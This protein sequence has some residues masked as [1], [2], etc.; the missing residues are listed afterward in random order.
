MSK[1]IVTNVLVVRV[2]HFSNVARLAAIFPV[3]FFWPFFTTFVAFDFPG[4]D[5]GIL[6]LFDPQ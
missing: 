6:P 5:V 2:Q 3:D 1:E 4:R